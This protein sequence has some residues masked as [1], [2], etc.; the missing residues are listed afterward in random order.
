MGRPLRW[1]GLIAASGLALAACRQDSGAP[2]MQANAKTI[3]VY[4]AASLTAPFT[5]LGKAFAQQEPQFVPRLVFEGS[6]SLVLKLHQGAQADVLATA[7]QSNMDK[8]VAAK[9]TATAPIEFAHNQLAILVP[10]GNPKSIATLA[11]LARP[12]YKVALCSPEVP[13][14]RYAREALAKA[15]VVVHTVSDETSVTAL[16]GKLQLGELD[17]GIAYVTDAKTQG[18]DAVAIPPAQ[19][20]TARY[21]IAVLTAGNE[22]AG[23]ERFVAF[24]RSEAGRRILAAHGFG[25]P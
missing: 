15:K 13:A 10:Q 14:G 6:P 7:D 11:D 21:P 1:L 19:N 24:V 2:D 8:I 20:I 12:D 9:L 4:A 22:R 3:V 18:L 5:E 25:T 16:C 17:A 23:G